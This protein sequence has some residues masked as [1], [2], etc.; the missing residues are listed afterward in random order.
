MMGI[1][2][3]KWS[4]T[5]LEAPLRSTVRCAYQVR[6]DKRF[7]QHQATLRDGVSRIVAPKG[8]GSSPVGHPLICR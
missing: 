4:S 8:A 7:P 2:R 6:G 1:A 5:L 3:R